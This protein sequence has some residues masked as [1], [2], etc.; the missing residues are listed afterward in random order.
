MFLLSNYKIFFKIF[1]LFFLLYPFIYSNQYYERIDYVKELVRE[2]NSFKIK[3]YKK[4]KKDD[5]PFL[6][7]YWKV[8]YYK[9]RIVAEELYQKNN[10]VYYYWY[11]YENDKVYQKGFFW[12]GIYTDIVYFKAHDKYIKQGWP[13]SNLMDVYRVFDLKTDKLTYEHIY[14][15]GLPSK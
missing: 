11:Y 5:T 4:V 3:I 1:I 8:Y 12:N 10:L 9:D 15:L 2:D 6:N 13:Y 7:S 14:N